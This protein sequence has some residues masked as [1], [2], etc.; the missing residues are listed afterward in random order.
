[1]GK[2]EKLGRSKHLIGRID[3]GNGTVI[4]TLPGDAGEPLDHMLDRTVRI[5]A[6]AMS[7]KN[8]NGQLRTNPECLGREEGVASEHPPRAGT[9][10][11]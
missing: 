5:T 6:T 1:V 11:K 9:Y 10:Q 7:S 3:S 8:D 2:R 4:A